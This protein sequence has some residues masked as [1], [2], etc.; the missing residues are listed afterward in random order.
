[1]CYVKL[2]T[3]CR[4]WVEF[5]LERP[6]LMAKPL[7]AGTLAM[8]MLACALGDAAPVPAPSGYSCSR[9]FLGRGDCSHPRRLAGQ[10]TRLCRRL[11]GGGAHGEHTPPGADAA[12]KWGMLS[13]WLS[14]RWDE[15]PG[16]LKGRLRE[17]ALQMVHD[18]AGISAS[19]NPHAPCRSC[20]Q[21][22]L[23]AGAR[24]ERAPVRT[25]GCHPRR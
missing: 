17:F 18:K 16:E 21:R 19:I 24:S 10:P 12:A 23:R 3:L 14:A 2:T 8:V 25:G 11:R 4:S 15:I 1:M 9:P 20:S 22:P 6:S 7:T 13:A 5:V